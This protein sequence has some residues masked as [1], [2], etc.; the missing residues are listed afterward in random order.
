MN[1]EHEQLSRNLEDLRHRIAESNKVI[2]SLEVTV[3]NRGSAAEEALDAYTNLLSTL[4]LFP[5]LPPPYEDV[6]LTL[7]LNTAASNP[8]QLLLGADLRRVIKPTLSGVAESKRIE[9]AGLESERIKVDNE[10]DQ[11]VLECENLEE[12]IHQ[13]EKKV[14]ALNEQAEDLREV[15]LLITR[16]GFSPFCNSTFRLSNKRHT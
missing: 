13:I 12:E 3:T 6:D 9:R 2:L 8:Q 1:T 7:E 14:V 15:S 16:S 5:P 11:L 4:G 10:L